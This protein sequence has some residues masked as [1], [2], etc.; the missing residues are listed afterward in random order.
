MV[1]YRQGTEET[2]EA[3]ISMGRDPREEFK[4]LFRKKDDAN[5]DKRDDATCGH[6]G[7][8]GTLTTDQ[9]LTQDTYVCAGCGHIFDLNDDDDDNLHLGPPVSSIRERWY[10]VPV[11]WCQCGVQVELPYTNPPQ[12]DEEGKTLIAGEDPLVLPSEG[13]SVIF[14]CYACG[15]L[16][17]YV[18][19]DVEA[20]P[21][22]KMTEGE[23]RSG[24]GV[25]L[26][27]FPC[28]DRH[29]TTPVSIHVDIGTGNASEAVAQLRSGIF[30]GKLMPCGHAM[31]T[32]PAKFYSVEAVTRRMW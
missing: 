10:F 26:A 1:P 17:R 12:T 11:V 3:V 25:Y 19:S 21:L 6:C 7:H 18:A 23:F 15:N 20:Y 28:G 13:W 24:E 27:R 9:M 22:L 14:G 5:R 16:S 4:A 32:V 31:K 30:D 8:V 29:C 2:P